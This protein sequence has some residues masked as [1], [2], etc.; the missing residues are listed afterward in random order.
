M[1]RGARHATA[2]ALL[3]AAG[4]GAS[5][6]P[7]GPGELVLPGTATCLRLG[8]VLRAETAT[9]R[10]T[11]PIAAA[12]PN[13]GRHRSAAAL[14]SSARVDLDARVPTASGPLRAYVSV[15]TGGLGRR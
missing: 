7:C 4:T 2:A 10:G 13:G 15:G 11:A 3:L 12:A 5:A 1:G 8:G 6:M 9:T 14:R